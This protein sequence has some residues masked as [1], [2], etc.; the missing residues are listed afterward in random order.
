MVY[1]TCRKT[2]CVNSKQTSSNVE[3]TEVANRFN[4]KD[5]LNDIARKDGTT[6]Q[7]SEE[8]SEQL[9]QCL[10]ETV[11]D[12]DR[13][14]RKH[15]IKLF[16]VGGTLLGAVRHKGFIPWD[17]D[18]DLGLIRSDYEKLKSV[19]EADFSDAYELRCPN[20]PYPN[21]GRYMQ[22]F[23]KGTVLKTVKKSNPLQPNCVYIDIFPYDYVPE[24]KIVRWVKGLHANTLMFIASCVMDE[25]YMDDEYKSYLK[26]SQD[27]KLFLTMRTITGKAFSFRSPERWFDLVDNAIQHKET[28]LLTS[29]TGRRH[30]FGEIYPVDI[31]IPLSELKFVNHDFYAPGGWEV[32]LKGNYGDDYMIPP[33]EGKRES[34]FI[35]DLSV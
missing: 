22:I 14:C 15:D 23:K 4:Y 1:V 8:E 30:Y 19:F 32:Y 13:R 25:K 26:K 11:V 28:K 20:S 27:G 7:I 6:R 10:Y 12:L 3:E 17:D 21:G 9:K 5:I 35:T 29:A 34:H 18:I 31:F 16:L 24:N 2:A 33:K